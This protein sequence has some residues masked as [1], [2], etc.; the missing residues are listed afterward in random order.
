MALHAYWIGRRA[1]FQRDLAAL[2]A[3]VD[4]A[5]LPTGE[6]PALRFNDLT[7]S[8]ALMALAYAAA[9]E[10]LDREAP[11]EVLAAPPMPPTTT[12]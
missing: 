3:H 9:S 8:A 11:E 1:R 6:A 2:P 10:H 12:S 7:Q 5:I 4:V